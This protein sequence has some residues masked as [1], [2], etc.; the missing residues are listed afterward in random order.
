MQLTRRA[1][2]VLLA[3]AAGT[4]R[5]APAER[6]R[7][8]DFERLWS[9][10]DE[11]YAYFGTA[12]RAEWRAA[13]EAWRPKARAARSREEF[14][15]ALEGL[16][17]RLREDHLWISVRPPNAPRRVPGETDIWAAWRG[18]SAVIEAVRTYGEADVAGI[19][20]G[21]V[22]RS[23]AGLP[24]ALAVRDL[25]ATREAPPASRDWALRHVLAGPRN[26]VLRVEVADVRG[27]Q[28]FE[29]ERKA[30]AA[31]TNG[32]TLIG[33]RVGEGRDLGY[34]R[35]KAPLSEP[36][37]PGR[38]EGAMNYLRDTRAM[39]LDLR[40][41]AGPFDDAARARAGTLA[42]LG[43]FAR[44]TLPWQSRESRTGERHIDSVDPLP[45]AYAAPLVVLVDRWTAG[46]GEALAAGLQA[47]A[48]ARLAGTR[49]A[50][51]RGELREVKLQHAGIAVR[52]PAEKAFHPDGT[53]RE[54]LRPA[55]L[56]DLAAP[57]G[58]PGDPILYQ[59]LK[60]LEK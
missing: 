22:V 44:R 32:P 37:L 7:L 13:R 43:R 35:L 54:S 15:A 42:I 9:A 25:L 23:V 12:G 29:I 38:F 14:A 34:I 10:I 50:G 58:G 19:R 48:G 2:L 51:L 47:V 59:A 31:S 36:A 16:L 3:A 21:H 30:G 26:G 27:G 4:A 57:Q 20:P 5:G 41:M 1:F 33:R 17:A 60:L 55:I 52:F 46:E 53:P 8:A 6:E 40:D 49:M 28:T 39:I 45:Q 11:G 18:D 24:A 56:V